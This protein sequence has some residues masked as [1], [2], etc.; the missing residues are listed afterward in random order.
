MDKHVR[1]PVQS[2]WA[3]QESAGEL[4]GSFQDTNLKGPQTSFGCQWLTW[5]DNDSRGSPIADVDRIH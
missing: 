4:L 1:E 5:I 2:S 3:S